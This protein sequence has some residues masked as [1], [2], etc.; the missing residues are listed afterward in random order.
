MLLLRTL[1]KNQPKVALSPV[2]FFCS[3][4][5]TLFL[6]HPTQ[7][8]TQ[9]SSAAAEIF[10][11]HTAR[12]R[13]TLQL[14]SRSGALH[15]PLATS[16]S[17]LQQHPTAR[18]T[19]HDIDDEDDSPQSFFFFVSLPAKLSEFRDATTGSGHFRTCRKPT[20]FGICGKECPHFR[21]STRNGLFFWFLVSSRSWWSKNF[22]GGGDDD[23]EQQRQ[24][25]FA[26]RFTDD[27]WLIGLPFLA[28]VRSRGARRRWPHARN[29]AHIRACTR[30]YIYLFLCWVYSAVKRRSVL[31][32]CR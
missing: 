10:N 30:K 31:K 20:C 2:F 23:D 21:A 1:G 19:T 11:Q 4:L 15:L 3:F 32:K 7:H 14:P 6:H 8:S 9:K 25:Q 28:C 13:P 27:D 18:R 12:R 29:D 5:T 16:C 22:W 24:K 17:F 26:F